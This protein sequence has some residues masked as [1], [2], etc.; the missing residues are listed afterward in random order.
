MIEYDSQIVPL[1][2]KFGKDYK[3]HKALD[4]LM[5]SKEYSINKAYILSPSNIE[6][7]KSNI[8]LPIY[9]TGLFENSKLEGVIINLNI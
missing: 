6:V 1:K 9:M 4:N 8:Y 5:N 2:I 3:K 7:D